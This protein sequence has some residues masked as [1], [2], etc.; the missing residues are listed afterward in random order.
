MATEVEV[1]KPSL[2]ESTR[3][4]L[5]DIRSEMRRVTWPSRQQ[6]EST[7]LVVILS[8]FVFA[9]YFTIVDKVI[10]QTVTRGYTSLVK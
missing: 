4:Y 1:K 7:T 6:V 3:E 9:A 10:E 2:V 5:N 8:V